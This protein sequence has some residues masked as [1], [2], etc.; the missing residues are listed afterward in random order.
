MVDRV[1]RS[2]SDPVR[3]AVSRHGCAAA[4]SR[5]H[6]HSCARGVSRR[7]AVR[8]RVPDTVLVVEDETAARAGMEQLL[9]RAGYD[10]VGAENGQA[11]LD[12]LRSGVRAKA[13]ILDLMMPVMDG[14]AFRREQLRDP[15]LAHIPVI[16]LSALHHGWVEG[17][18]PTLPKPIDVQQLLAELE[19]VLTPPISGGR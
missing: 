17:I 13:I 14:W 18:P 4:D 10:A 5:N 8:S 6:E 16:V 19:E 11:A 2:R 15:H 7:I 9:R 3:L 12:L 1:C